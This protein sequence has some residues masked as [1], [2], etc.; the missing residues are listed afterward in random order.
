M[1]LTEI[2]M[3]CSAFYV[4]L[5]FVV[6]ILGIID[7]LDLENQGFYIELTFWQI[8]KTFLFCIFCA[9]GFIIGYTIFLLMNHFIRY[10]MKLFRPSF[11]L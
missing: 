1:S 2:V 9:V 3:I 5:G 10:V 8:I 7:T 4:I 6:F 11:L